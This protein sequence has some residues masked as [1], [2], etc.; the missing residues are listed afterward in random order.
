MKTLDASKDCRITSVIG[1]K[2]GQNVE[3]IMFSYKTLEGTAKRA[4]YRIGN[5]SYATFKAI[6]EAEHLENFTMHERRLSKEE[7]SAYNLAVA[8]KRNRL[9]I[10]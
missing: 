9:G 7:F 10:W 6:V 3:R 4:M 5:H 8:H 2:H 1:R